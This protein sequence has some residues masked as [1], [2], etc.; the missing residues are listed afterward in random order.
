MNIVLFA[1]WAVFFF[2]AVFEFLVVTLRA[3]SL[4][5]KAERAFEMHHVW[6]WYGESSDV[7]MPFA[8]V[9]PKNTPITTSTTLMLV[10]ATFISASNARKWWNQQRNVVNTHKS[11]LKIEYS[12]RISLLRCYGLTCS[13]KPVLQFP[14]FLSLSPSPAFSVYHS[15]KEVE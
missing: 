1:A 14:C 11:R 4:S 5:T 6:W 8:P 3:L 9:E 2:C 15:F 10:F 7:I 13:T 12:G